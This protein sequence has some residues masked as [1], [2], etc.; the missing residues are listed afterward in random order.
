MDQAARR[1]AWAGVS[2]RSRT[3]QALRNALSM[4][5]AVRLMLTDVVTMRGRAAGGG[6]GR[7]GSRRKWLV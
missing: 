7:R 5:T 2:A 4:W 6:G 3:E 1:A